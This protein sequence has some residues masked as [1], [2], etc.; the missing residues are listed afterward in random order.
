M[1]P[2]RVMETIEILSPSPSL[3]RVQP[4]AEGKK[5]GQ[6]VVRV[7][8][9]QRDQGSD[10]VLSAFE[11]TVNTLDGIYRLM[12]HH[13][14]LSGI[15]TEIIDVLKNIDEGDR[16]IADA[17]ESN[18]ANEAIES[19]TRVLKSLDRNPMLESKISKGLVLTKRSQGL[20]I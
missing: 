5:K 19:Y 12:S 11:V 1:S 4:F 15:E 18:A 6:S 9:V 17:D 13:M 7:R 20:L 8:C 14:G 10:S 16:K 3:C 2:Q